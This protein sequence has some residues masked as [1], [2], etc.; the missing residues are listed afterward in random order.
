MGRTKS[1]PVGQM[2]FQYNINTNES[3][4]QVPN[5]KNP[6]RTCNHSGNL[7][8]HIKYFHKEQYDILLKKKK[9]ITSYP[10]ED[11]STNKRQKIEKT[12]PLDEMIIISKKTL[13]NVNL[14]KKTVVDACVQLVTTNGLP[15]QLLD[16]SGFRMIMNPIFNAIGDGSR[17]NFTA[18]CSSRFLNISAYYT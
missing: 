8:N 2:F 9:K 7:E 11:C 14:D 3:T 10:T 12:G 15:F 4:C 1:N 16:D 6:V 18:R 13:K 5:C 17:Y